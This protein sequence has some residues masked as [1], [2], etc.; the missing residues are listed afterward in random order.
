MEYKGTPKGNSKPQDL[1]NGTPKSD[2]EKKKATAEDDNFAKMSEP[3]ALTNFFVNRPFAW[4]LIAL[5]VLGTMSGVVF[6]LDWFAV[7][8]VTSRDY[9]IWDDPKTINYD[10][11]T[12][13]RSVLV[14]GG[15]GGSAESPLQTAVEIEWTMFL[16]Y[17]GQDVGESEDDTIAAEGPPRGSTWSRETLLAIRDMEAPVRNGEGFNQFCLADREAILPPSPRAQTSPSYT[18]VQ[19]ARAS[20]LSPVD[21]LYF[22]GYLP[23]D[24]ET[25]TQE[26]L[27]AVLLSVIQDEA[28]WENFKSLFDSEVSADHLEVRYIRSQLLFAGP[29][30]YQTGEKDKNGNAVY[31]RYASMGDRYDEQSQL[32]TDFQV[33]LS[34]ALE[35]SAADYYPAVGRKFFSLNL[36][37]HRFMEVA[38][39]D[40]QFAVFSV[41][42][43]FFYIW[44]HLRSLFLALSANICILLSFPVTQFIYRGVLQ[45]GLYT[46]MNNLI[47]FIVLGIAA[48]NIFVFCDAWRQSEHIPI[49]A[50]N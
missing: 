11:S 24:L 15:A 19:C 21:M 30:Q 14:S 5:L 32:V 7:A 35:R 47:V 25:I 23:H 45:V 37:R 6:Y 10:K 18:D 4:L 34:D 44:F 1:A 38:R 41:L 3:T 31:A 42:F 40:T 43:V 46:A 29:L 2:I 50:N 8:A 49:M 33:L 16:I 28:S 12:L 20:F 9:L 27:D 36:Y 39:G 22:R 48:D 26:E 13:A 17:S